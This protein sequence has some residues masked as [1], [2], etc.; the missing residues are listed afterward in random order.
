MRR[1]ERSP[2]TNTKRI[3]RARRP[4]L[5]MTKEDE[6]D[7]FEKF[8]AD[9]HSEPKYILSQKEKSDFLS[10]PGMPDFDF[11]SFSLPLETP[12]TNSKKEVPRRRAKSA[13]VTKARTAQ[14]ESQLRNRLRRE[15]FSSECNPN[16]V[17]CHFHL[18]CLDETAFVPTAQYELLNE[19]QRMLLRCLPRGTDISPRGGK[20]YPGDNTRRTNDTY[21]I[22]DDDDKPI[23][24]EFEKN[25]GSHMSLDDT[26]SLEFYLN[27]YQQQ[28]RMREEKENREIS[29]TET[30]LEFKDVEE[31]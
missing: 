3:P 15:S 24:W 23:D 7:D 8:M 1:V 14:R 17:E 22:E 11:A 25:R 26:N 4:R 20:F 12:R 28:I 2:K 30:L 6:L 19:T 18:L 21:I 31:D 5:T 16:D 13:D 27:E 9:L 10:L 29:R